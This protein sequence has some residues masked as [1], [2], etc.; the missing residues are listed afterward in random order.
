MKLIKL[1]LCFFVM[2]PFFS[3]AQNTNYAKE[4]AVYLENN[5]T[6]N[7]YAYA[8][9][10]LLK[11]LGNQFPK[12]DKN[13]QGWSYLETNKEKAIAEIKALLVP[14]YEQN[15]KQ[16]DMRKMIAFYK[17]GAGK[18]LIA[19]RT[20]LTENQKKEL[21]DFYASEVGKKI[22]EKQPILTEA[23]AKVSEGWS[24]DLYETAMSLLK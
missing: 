9:D 2:T 22:I 23:I 24:R 12:T 7:Q 13:A 11:M 1:L 16:E 20:K 17:D 8:Y 10:E 15:F 18:Q 3:S 21:N 5:G 19:D 4:V 14:I 6:E